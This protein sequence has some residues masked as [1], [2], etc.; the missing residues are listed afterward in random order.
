MTWIL[1]ALVWSAVLA[2]PSQLVA[3]AYERLLAT[4]AGLALGHALQPAASA[5]ADLSAATTLGV[6]SALCLASA[7]SSWPHRT[8]ALLLGLGVLVAI[9]CLTG[10]AAIAAGAAQSTTGGWAPW[11][12]HSLEAVL[13]VPRFASAPLLW[14]WFLGRQELQR[15]L[16]LPTPKRRSDGALRRG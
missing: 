8:R 9:E 6:F 14:L 4:L 1:R 5:P 11:V 15:N 2:V 10:V 16:Q 3:P 13:A 7:A 12:Q